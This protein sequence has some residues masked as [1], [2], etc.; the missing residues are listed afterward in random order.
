M[1]TYATSYAGDPA[2]GAAAAGARTTRQV[3]NLLALLVHKYKYCRR[4]R[5]TPGTQFTFFT[6]TEVQI[7]TQK[8]QH[9]RPVARGAPP[10]YK[11][12]APAPE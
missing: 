4:R 11:E 5:N 9:A 1:L 10:P 6:S 2:A 8:A 7:L 3:L 12:P